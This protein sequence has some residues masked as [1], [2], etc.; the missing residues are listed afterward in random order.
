MSAEVCF[1]RSDFTVAVLKGAIIR[2]EVREE[3]I[4]VMRSGRMSC[5][6]FW[7][8]GEGIRS[9]E[10]VVAQLDVTSV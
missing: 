7:R 2:P 8:R 4:S 9:R 10:Q 5:E 3:L 1:F 6:M